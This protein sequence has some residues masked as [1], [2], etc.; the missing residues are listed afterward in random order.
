MYEE[1]TEYSLKHRDTG[2]VMSSTFDSEYE[3]NKFRS[4]YIE[5]QYDW[6]IVQRKVRTYEWEE[7]E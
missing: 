4:R 5:R 3:V 1:T 7:I 2:E 6:Q